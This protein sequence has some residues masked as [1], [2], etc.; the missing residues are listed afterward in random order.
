MPRLV[1]GTSLFNVRQYFTEISRD[2][3]AYIRQPY[4]GAAKPER[5]ESAARI[6][7]DAVSIR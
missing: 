5:K 3:P 4:L 2:P 7:P 1:V 6:R